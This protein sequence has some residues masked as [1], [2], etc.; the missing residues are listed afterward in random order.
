MQRLVASC[1]LMTFGRPPQ[2]TRAS[3]PYAQ[4]VEVDETFQVSAWY[5]LG[6]MPVVIASANR[7][8]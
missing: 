1:S 7:V 5:S 4:I 6:R 8:S 2:P 3:P